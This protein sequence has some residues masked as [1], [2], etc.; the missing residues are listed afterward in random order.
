MS[1]NYEWY[2]P[3]PNSKHYNLRKNSA[4]GIPSFNTIFKEKENA[5]YYSP[6]IW[7]RVPD[8]IKSLESL[9]SLKKAVKKW[10]TPKSYCRLC[11]TFLNS[12]KFLWYWILYVLRILFCF[13]HFCYNLSLFFCLTFTSIRLSLISILLNSN[14]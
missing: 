8:E 9:T 13:Q 1:R 3:V 2:F 10:V 4:F 6:K 7:N 14:F 5:S 12:V 11:R